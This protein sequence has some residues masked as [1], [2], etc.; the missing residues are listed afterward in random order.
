MLISCRWARDLALRGILKLK[1]FYFASLTFFLLE[2]SAALARTPT[3][4]CCQ[5]AWVTTGQSAAMTLNGLGNLAVDASTLYVP[6]F[7]NNQ[8]QK[9]T[10]SGQP[11]G[12]LTGFTGPYSVAMGPHATLTVG[13]IFNGDV[14]LY[15][16]ATQNVTQV[17]PIS[18][19][20]RSLWVDPNGDLYVTVSFN[21]GPGQVDIFRWTGSAYDSTAVT[22]SAGMGNLP[23]GLA[24]VMDGATT[25]L[26]VADA[27]ASE[28]LEYTQEPN[29]SFGLPATVTANIPVG[30]SQIAVDSQG[31]L[32]IGS[33]NNEYAAFTKTLSP[34][35]TCNSSF[36]LTGIA[37]DASDDVYSAGFYDSGL[38]LVDKVQEY[39]PCLVTPTPTFAG[40]EICF[41][42]PSPARGDHATVAYQMAQAGGMEFK[43]WNQNGELVETLTDHKS[44]GSQTTP[45]KISGFASGV[46]FYILTLRY[47][48][49]S[50][51]KSKVGKFVV[52]Q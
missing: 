48:S 11:A 8:I 38:G 6:D 28:V 7:S 30:P 9:F 43:L 19:D 20:S 23:T 46:Y 5:Q 40:S 3:S 2:M 51:Q 41:I 26:Y 1:I 25:L 36:E 24:K 52:L 31:D 42:Y 49:G 35:Y 14:K 44:A 21:S 15:D 10:L 33:S 13:E 39:L 22:V 32:F 18:G 50:T 12:V 16:L 4:V 27:T 17:L 45:F 47:D 37:V 34:L 29:Y